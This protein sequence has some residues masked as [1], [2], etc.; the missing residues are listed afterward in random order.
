MDLACI[1][2]ASFRAAVAPVTVVML[3]GSPSG[4]ASCYAERT[5]QIGIDGLKWIVDSDADH[6]MYWRRTVEGDDHR[7]QKR[8]RSVNNATICDLPDQKELR[9]LQDFMVSGGSQDVS[10]NTLLAPSSTATRTAARLAGSP[11]QT[12]VRSRKPVQAEPGFSEPPS[13]V[14]PVPQLQPAGK[15]V[16]LSAAIA[17]AAPA[18]MASTPTR[19]AR[20]EERLGVEGAPSQPLARLALLEVHLGASPGS[21]T[22]RLS[23]LETSAELQGL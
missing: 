14:I 10:A 21:I 7:P 5:V 12:Q 9:R 8:A 3:V 11:V 17:S 4:R 15:G 13:A 23:A 22:D 16:L 6:K 1:L 2:R 20:L 19:L 18:P